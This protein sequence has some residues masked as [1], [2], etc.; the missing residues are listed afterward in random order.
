MAVRTTLSGNANVQGTLLSSGLNRF[1]AV[2]WQTA[3]LKNKPLTRDPSTSRNITAFGSRL[4]LLTS[5]IFCR[6]FGPR[7][8]LTSGG[9]VVSPYVE[10]SRQ[11]LLQRRRDGPR[12]SSRDLKEFNPTAGASPAYTGRALLAAKQADHEVS[13]CEGE[14]L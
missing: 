3:S 2:S 10:E 4:S 9:G 12:P 14:K 11:G 1:K 8:V 6:R 7:R 13:E 5:P